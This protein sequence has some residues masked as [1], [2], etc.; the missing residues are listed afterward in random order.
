MGLRFFK[1]MCFF[2]FLYTPP[3][4][5]VLKCQLNR[6]IVIRR[7]IFFYYRPVDAR[8]DGLDENV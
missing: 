8:A 7:S 6:T 3:L 4:P 5:S 1:S 2:M